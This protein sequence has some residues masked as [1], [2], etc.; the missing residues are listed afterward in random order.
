MLNIFQL[1]NYIDTMQSDI[2]A[3][4]ST[5]GSNLLNNVRTISN[6][7]NP[8]LANS[9]QTA[10]QAAD[11]TLDTQQ[12]YTAY[13][14]AIQAARENSGYLEFSALDCES[15]ERQLARY[16]IEWHR[17]FSLSMACL[18]LFFIGVPLGAIIRKGGLG[19]PLTV[20]IL[21]FVLYW[22]TSTIGERMARTGTIP[23]YIGMW[24]SSVLLL[25]MGIFLIVMASR[26]ASLSDMSAL[27]KFFNKLSSI[28]PL[29]KLSVHHED[30]TSMQ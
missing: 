18:L 9:S 14:Y 26:E 21:V 28:N 2:F 27:K 22:V 29:H 7:Y 10:V 5:R 8:Q 25:P 17:K 1:D 24:I 16:E 13:T 12:T 23:P 4:E 3:V 6:Y 20:S 19:I 11:D 15:Q 30:S